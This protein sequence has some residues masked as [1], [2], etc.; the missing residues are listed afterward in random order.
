MGGGEGVKRGKLKW[1]VERGTIRD[2]GK[3]KGVINVK[4]EHRSKYRHIPG[5]E[6][7]YFWR[8]EGSFLD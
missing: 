1:G 2:S 7:H 4:W 8:A 3:C 6:K 5:G